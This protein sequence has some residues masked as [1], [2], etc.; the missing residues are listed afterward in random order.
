MCLNQKFERWIMCLNH[1]WLTLLKKVPF[2][3]CSPS[4]SSFFGFKVKE[5]KQEKKTNRKKGKQL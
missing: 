5:A 3:Q 1:P 4:F 2:M